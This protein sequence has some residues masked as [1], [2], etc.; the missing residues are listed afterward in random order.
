MEVCLSWSLCGGRCAAQQKD[1]RKGDA[2][3]RIDQKGEVPL[4]VGQ[5]AGQR[6]GQHERQVVDG[7]AVTQLPDAVVAREVVDH[8]SR[9]EG[10]HH[11]GTH[12]QE[13]TDD[14]QLGHA[15]CKEAGHAAQEEERKPRGQERELVAPFGNFT[16]QQHEGDDEQRRKRR[17][18][19]NLEVGGMGKDAVHVAQNGGDG[20]PRQRGDGRDGPDGKQRR[21]RNG[22]F[23]GSDFHGCGIFGP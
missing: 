21:E 1:G 19:L 13:R 23:A 10:N 15:P 8:K 6:R 17:E 4:D 12:A 5:I 16:R 3:Q 7:R 20:Q 11:A 9:R 18:H 14:N 22:P 2:R